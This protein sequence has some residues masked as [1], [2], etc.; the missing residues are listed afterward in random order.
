MAISNDLEWFADQYAIQTR[1]YQKEA[2]VIEA[3]AKSVS[4]F[5][6]AELNREA[7]EHTAALKRIL[8]T[9]AAIEHAT[10]EDSTD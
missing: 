6:R 1:I 5:R 2:D 7:A 3:D 4:D 8:T 9:L 10:E